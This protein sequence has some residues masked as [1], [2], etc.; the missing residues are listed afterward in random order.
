[1]NDVYIIANELDRLAYL[2]DPYEY[3]DVIG[4]RDEEHMKANVEQI[5]FDLRAGNWEP[6]IEWLREIIEDEN[7]DFSDRVRATS[8]L[9]H[10]LD[11]IE[12]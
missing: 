11:W 10:L 5:V 9:A 2:V 1:M 4:G 12:K 7:N 3:W 8:R 6:Y